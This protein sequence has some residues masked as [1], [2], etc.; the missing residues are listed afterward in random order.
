MP[1]AAGAGG[2]STEVTTLADL[3][4][5]RGGGDCWR[6]CEFGG[7]SIDIDGG[8]VDFF[9]VERGSTKGVSLGISELTCIL[10]RSLR[11]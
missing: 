3:D 1:L 6:R 5:G 7:S 2:T 9:V 4:E 8:A 11:R 10:I